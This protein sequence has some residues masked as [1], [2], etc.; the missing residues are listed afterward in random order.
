MLWEFSVLVSYGSKAIRSSYSVPQFCLQTFFL[1]VS[2]SSAAVGNLL[3]FDFKIRGSKI[4]TS[5][6]ILESNPN[7]FIFLNDQSHLF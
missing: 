2:L 1:I 7:L 3:G 5:V 6:Y 4:L